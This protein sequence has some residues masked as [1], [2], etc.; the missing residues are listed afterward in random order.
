MLLGDYHLG[1]PF[2]AF[3]VVREARCPPAKGRQARVAVSSRLRARR[4]SGSPAKPRGLAS[5]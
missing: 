1:L 3:G 4:R 5:L 2:Q